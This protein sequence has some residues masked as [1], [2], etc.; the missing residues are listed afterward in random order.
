M[1]YRAGKEH[2]VSVI[3]KDGALQANQTWAL[4]AAYLGVEEKEISRIWLANAVLSL[5]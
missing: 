1:Q 4:F 2:A 5:I 3:C